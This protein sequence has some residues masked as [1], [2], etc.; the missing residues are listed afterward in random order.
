MVGIIF[1]NPSEAF[2]NPEPTTS[3]IMAKARYKYFISCR[4]VVKI[5]K[6]A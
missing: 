4:K 3:K 6:S 5:Q 1:E 2:K